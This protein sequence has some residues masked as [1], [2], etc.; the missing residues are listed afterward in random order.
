MNAIEDRAVAAP[1]PERAAAT[2]SVVILSD[3]Q[4]DAA[5]ATAESVVAFG[6]RVW[7]FERGPVTGRP[8]T[9]AEVVPVEWHARD[10][11]SS[12]ITAIPDTWILV[13]AAGETV[14]CDDAAA[15]RKELASL[16]PGPVEVAL[17]AGRE[18]RLHPPTSD[19][20][21]AVGAPGRAAASTFSIVPLGRPPEA[22]AQT[23]KPVMLHLGCGPN[24]FE[25]WVNVDFDA[26]YHPDV[27]CDLSKSL[28]AEPGTVDLIYSEHFLEHVTLAEGLALLRRCRAALRPGGVVRIAMPDLRAVIDYYLGDW[29]DQDWLRQPEYA[30]IDSA[31]HMLNYSLREWGH[32]YLY[33]AAEL[34]LRLEQ[35]GFVDVRACEWGESDHPELRNRETRVDS[36]LIMEGRA[37]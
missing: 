14:A 12:A 32:Q 10:D 33:D 23:P 22:P 25:G 30:A 1:S 6:D 7:I 36:R 27:V 34:R 17:L 35:A 20:I 21:E 31:A 28:P 16:E 5:C 13:L 15:A 11:A 19:A 18:V 2:L 4:L 37:P 26:Q 24:H 3:R 9:H 29:K 8:S